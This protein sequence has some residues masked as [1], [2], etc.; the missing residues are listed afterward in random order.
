MES[1]EMR[2]SEICHAC[3]GAG[4]P[5]AMSAVHPGDR[6]TEWGGIGFSAICVGASEK[7]VLLLAT[8]LGVGTREQRAREIREYSDCS[9][10]THPSSSAAISW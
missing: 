7:A 10:I 2:E 9:R 6:V 1:P 4:I 3:R 5:C 8:A